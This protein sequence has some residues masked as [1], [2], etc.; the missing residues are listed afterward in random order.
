MFK[1]PLLV[2][3]VLVLYTVGPLLPM[4]LAS[5]IASHYGCQL[6]EGGLYPCVVGGRDI[7]GALG[8]MFVFAWLELFTLPSGTL[9]LFIYGV[10]H[11]F[12]VMRARTP[13]SL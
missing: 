10:Y 3:T 12:R 9:A 8:S 4:L 11:I 5:A 1:R 6:D 13:P 7:G 2:Y